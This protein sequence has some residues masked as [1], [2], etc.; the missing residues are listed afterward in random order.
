MEFGS[1]CPSRAIPMTT[2]WAKISSTVSSVSRFIANSISPGPV[3]SPMYSPTWRPSITRSD[4][5]L[6]WAGC[7]Q[8][9]LNQ[10]SCHLALHK[11][12]S[13]SISK[14]HSVFFSNFVSI[15]REGLNQKRPLWA[16]FFDR[17]SHRLFSKSA[18]WP[19]TEKGAVMLDNTLLLPDYSVALNCPVFLCSKK[20]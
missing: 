18:A 12:S 11:R 9:S 7:L 20:L 14:I 16:D 8:P 15:F 19:G 6:H 17:R 1:A 13:R 3:H 4:H 2:P 5:I 10:A